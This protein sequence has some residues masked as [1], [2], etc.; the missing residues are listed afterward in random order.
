MRTNTIIGCAGVLLLAGCAAVTAPP[1]Y[2]GIAVETIVDAIQ[3]E[4]ASV[5]ITNPKYAGSLRNWLARSVLDLKVIN[6]GNFSPT[7]TVIPNYSPGTLKVPIG[8]DL[9]D[10]SIRI[11]SISFDV[12]MRDLMPIDP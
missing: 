6:E 7:V 3:C 11:A 2:D 10:Q 9:R 8:P 1:R 12:H 5:Y 4:L